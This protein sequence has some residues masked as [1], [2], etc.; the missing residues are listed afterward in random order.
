MTHIADLMP[1]DRNARRHNPRN[2]GM[3]ERSLES[4]GFG[5]SLLVA[6]DG[7]IIAGN[8]TWS[9]CATAGIEDVLVV[10]SDGTRVIAVKRTDIASGT[11]QFHALAVAD[12]RTTDLSS[13]DPQ[14]LAGLVADGSVVAT[15]FWTDDEWSG[16]MDQAATE[17]TGMDEDQTEPCPTCGRPIR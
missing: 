12:N 11:P 14:V 3:I 16:L 5:R 2:E 4:N 13:F 8:A 17:A 15:D 7:T 9:A 1:D 10:E 6:N